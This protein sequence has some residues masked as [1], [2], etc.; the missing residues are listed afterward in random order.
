M[1]QERIEDIVIRL[2]TPVAE[3]LK[4]ELVDVEYRKE[5]SDWV[6]RCFID[7]ETGVGIDDCQ[8]FSN[9]FEKVMDAA[10]PI[11]GSYLLEVSSPGLERPLKKEKDYI[12]F[13]GS[14]VEVK[15]HKALNERKKYQGELLGFN[16]A[17]KMVRLKTDNR[18]IEIPLSEI[19]KA[20]LIVEF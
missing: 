12:R 19:A 5:G 4:L 20:N 18:E 14:R 6:L 15:L 2:G 10:D 3:E 7:T 1:K 17:E 11:P 16:E 8:R 13:T 9:A